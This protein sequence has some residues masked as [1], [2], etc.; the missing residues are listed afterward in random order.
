MD[1]SMLHRAV[2]LPRCSVGYLR[3]ERLDLRRWRAL[4]K[5]GL[6]TSMLLL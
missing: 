1:A 4:S 5:L 6:L 3:A 2:S